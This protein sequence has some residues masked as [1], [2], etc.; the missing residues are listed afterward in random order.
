MSTEQEVQ[1]LAVLNAITDKIIAVRL[2]YTDNSALVC[3]NK[4]A[5]QQCASS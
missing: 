3:L 5:K 4:P 2:R 1:E